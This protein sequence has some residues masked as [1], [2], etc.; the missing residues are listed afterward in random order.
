MDGAGEINRN[1]NKRRFDVWLAVQNPVGNSGLNLPFHRPVS[2]NIQLPTHLFRVSKSDPKNKKNFWNGLQ[3][4]GLYPDLY[5]GL[6]PGPW[7]YSHMTLLCQRSSCSTPAHPFI[8]SLV[9]IWISY[10][11]FFSFLF[12]FFHFVFW[13]VFMHP[14]FLKAP[15]FFPFLSF[16]SFHFLV[17]QFQN[18]DWIKANERE[19]EKRKEK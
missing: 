17:C 1:K 7:F 10:S 18:S 11:F 14:T 3:Y 8:P 15:I 12:S 16:I 19:E 6:H 13:R 5:P 2:T 4:P 9:L